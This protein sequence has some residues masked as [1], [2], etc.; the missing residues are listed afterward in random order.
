MNDDCESADFWICAKLPWG[1]TLQTL[2]VKL[3]MNEWSAFLIS[4]RLQVL[5]AIPC[6][7]KMNENKSEFCKVSSSRKEHE[8]DFKTGWLG[9]EG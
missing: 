5:T 3:E 8:N 7:T 1:V 9:K 6:S 4:I 2:K